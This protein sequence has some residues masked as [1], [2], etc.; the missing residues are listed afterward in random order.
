MVNTIIKSVVKVFQV[1]RQSRQGAREGLTMARKLIAAAKPIKSWPDMTEEEKDAFI[2][3]LFL[4]MK[5]QVLGKED[6]S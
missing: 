1:G 2:N 3:S 6:K 5:E 4:Q